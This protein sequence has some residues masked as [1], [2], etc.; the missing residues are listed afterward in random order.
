MINEGNNS[1]GR[2]PLKVANG[3]IDQRQQP[4]GELTDDTGARKSPKPTHSSLDNALE[5]LTGDLVI[6]G[7]YRGSILRSAK[8][9]FQQLW[10]PLK[11]GLNIRKVDLEVGLTQEDEEKMHEKIIASG[12]LSHIGPIDMGR[13]LLRRL[14]LCTNAQEGRLRIHEY[15]YDWRLSPHLLS[16]RLVEF[17][18]RLP[19]NRPGIPKHERGATVIAHSMGGL[20]TRHA[21]NHCPSLFAGVVYAGVPQHCINILGPSATATMS[22]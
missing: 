4:G 22:S 1:N 3:P 16:R 20:I 18:E 6:M 7:G 9:P 10:V 11:V 21:V 14:R 5:K 19:C 13:R 12:M 2:A 8:P 17:L 15:G